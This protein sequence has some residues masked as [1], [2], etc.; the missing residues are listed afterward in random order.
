MKRQIIWK[1][2]AVYV[3]LL[4]SI[5]LPLISA[6]S[7]PLGYLYSSVNQR[8]YTTTIESYNWTNARDRCLELGGV[9]ATITS[10]ELNS[11]IRSSYNAS[12]LWLGYNDQSSEG[13]FVW[14]SG[15]ISSYTNWLSGEPNNSGNEDCVVMRSSGQWDDQN[16]SLSRVGVCQQS[17]TSMT[18]PAGYTL[19]LYN[20]R[21]YKR[22]TDPMTW[23]DAQT[24]CVS[25]GGNLATITSITLNT[26]IHDTFMPNGETY[27]LWLGLNDIA[28][29][30]A[31]VWVSG[32]TSTFRNW[33]STQ[34]DNSGGD[35]D[36][37]QMWFEGGWNDA[38][39]YR[40]SEAVFGHYGLC[41][42]Y[43]EYSLSQNPTQ[44]PSITSTTT[45]YSF[46]IQFN[47]HSIPLLDSNEDIV[48][49]FFKHLGISHISLRINALQ[50]HF[51]HPRV[52]KHRYLRVSQ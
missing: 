38:W 37:V 51:T 23:Y 42:K 43:P 36:C 19:S 32:D 27:R 4:L 5:S 20:S 44:S 25:D 41:E 8:C 13:T 49:S 30:G 40:V 16:C 1:T 2:L 35:E 50:I 15:E 12:N 48:T 26:L 11:F 17:A 9:L 10:S 6:S 18:C 29:E 21:C 7:C 14:E 3:I 31:Y 22:S 47:N 33:D 39:C 34:P 28:S 46:R 52:L 24:A 45:K